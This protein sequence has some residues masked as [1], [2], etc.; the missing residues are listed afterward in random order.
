MS[1]NQHQQNKKISERI[2][3]GKWICPG[4]IVKI[5][6][7]EIK[8]GNFYYGGEELKAKD[9]KWRQTITN[10]PEKGRGYVKWLASARDDPD[11]Y[12]GYVFLYFYGI[13]RRL[14]VDRKELFPSDRQALIDEIWRLKRIYDGDS[15]FNRNA[16]NLLAHVWVLIHEKFR[17]IAA[18]PDESLLTGTREFTSAF[19]YLLG[20]AVAGGAPV[21][22]ELALAWVRSHPE[23]NLRTPASRY[24]E[25]FDSLFK[26]RYQEKFGQGITIWPD[27]TKLQL[28]YHPASPTLF[29][30][31]CIK[32]DI[33][34]LN[35]SRLIHPLIKLMQLAESCID[36][37]DT[38]NRQINAMWKDYYSPESSYSD[39]RITSN[40]T[41]DHVR[42]P[43][44][45]EAKPAKPTPPGKWISPGQTV[46]IAN[47]DVK[48]GYFYYGKCI[49]PSSVIDPTLKIGKSPPPDYTRKSNQVWFRY[50]DISPQN[51]AAYIEW[52]ASNRDDP[53]CYIGYV[54]LYFYGIERRLLV[55]AEDIS[56]SERGALIDE[57]WRLKRIYGGEPSFN[58]DATNLLVHVGGL[59]YRQ[60]E[61]IYP[62]QSLL[63]GT[64]EFTSVFKYLLG[65]TVNKRAPVSSEL[66][67]AWVR[68][69]PDYSLQ[70]PAKRCAKEFDLLFKL[71]YKEKY[72]QGIMIKP[73]KTQLQLV[74]RPA[75]SAL[76]P[77]LRYSNL[78]LPDPSRLKAPVTKL[79]QLAESCTDE[80]DAYCRYIGKT[81]NSK[82]SLAAFVYL[83]SVLTD[84]VENTKFRSLKSWLRC[85]T[86]NS[87]GIVQTEDLS[88][89][90][91]GNSPIKINK[92]EAETL[93][94]LVEKAGFGLAPDIR[95][96]HAKPEISGCVVIFENGHGPDF[97]PGDEFNHLGTILRLGAMIATVDGRVDETEIS[98][99]DRLISDNSD[100]SET[101][102]KSLH[103]Y[104]HWRLKTR[105]DMSG[106]KNRL[107]NLNCRQKSAIGHILVGV[108]LADG[109]IEP[110][111][112]KQLR[113][114]YTSLGLD[115]ALVPN[116]IH[117]LKSR[118][119]KSSPYGSQTQTKVSNLS[120]PAT[121]LNPVL[122]DVCKEET[123]GVKAV[124]DSIFV[125]ENIK[126]ENEN[127]RGDVV[128]TPQITGLD[129][130]HTRFYEKLICKDKWSSEEVEDIC[131]ELNLM[132]YGAIEVINEWAFNNVNAPLIEDEGVINI[133]LEVA[134]EIRA[135]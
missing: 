87:F 97:T 34:D 46:K 83:P 128:A 19:R 43:Q 20:K 18:Q 95:F 25:E 111:E 11:C 64:R 30:R 32:L 94:S 107:K 61:E 114:L 57:I 131:K 45:I 3:P 74:Y 22:S 54:F 52:L 108:A 35:P 75:S 38:Y 105:P 21:S 120:S 68:S 49:Y 121:S 124:L 28:V 122:L 81:A 123:E 23:Y 126:D 80:L 109:K 60:R 125:E 106:L 16:T 13:E 71:R 7:F 41:S 86:T 79:M 50:R 24:A 62:D 135:L 27:N 66:A 58:R 9:D 119:I 39:F 4:E 6:D 90:V 17:T 132:V 100:L 67:L 73:N 51:R 85:K 69:H 40:P 76:L 26:L 72:G 70:T 63:T 15:T 127:I 113:K 98:V 56:P 65:K 84:W 33:P 110:M 77:G 29:G 93:A 55:D 99:L 134:Q 10:D 101:E 103:A 118:K 31:H 42:K 88:S 2:S 37:L 91:W 89:K 112:I 53:T 130:A 36:E 92:K 59:Y 117:N 102:K 96:H 116:D 82:E 104:L 133:D 129:D 47:S 115:D 14:L 1:E 44:S 8:G 12:M 48:G 5:A 78:D